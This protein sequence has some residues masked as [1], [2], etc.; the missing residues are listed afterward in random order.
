MVVFLIFISLDGWSQTNRESLQ[1]T[2]KQLEEEIKYTNQLLEQTQKSKKASLSKINLLQRQIEKREKL[3]KTINN[4]IAEIDGEIA[5]QIVEVNKKA[6][7]LRKMKDEYARLIYFIYKNQNIYNRIM[8]IFAADDFNQAYN[9]LKYYQQYTVYR[10]T[11][12]SLVRKAQ[13]D[14]NNQIKQLAETKD[15]KTSLA[16]KKAQEKNRLITEKADKDKT[17]QELTQKEKQLAAKLKEKQQASYKLQIEIE[18]L[19]AKEIKASNEKAKKAAKADTKTKTTTGVNDMVLTPVEKELST[20]FAANRGKLPWPSEKGVI[21]SSFGEHSHPVLKHVKVKNNGID[22]STEENAG[23]RTVFA[24][25][26]SRVMSFPNMNYVVIIRH[27][28][29]LT[30]YSN[31]DEVMVKDGQEVKTKQMIGRVH[32]NADEAK[33]EYHF[34]LWYGKTILNPQLW[35]AGAN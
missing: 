17:V 33:T 34:E 18:K 20:S 32:A 13:N 2:K 10:R 3:L 25:K 11:Q 7:E 1:R 29:Y 9:R 5:T 23:I 31:L 26:V 12:A 21:T 15:E 16:L 14:L 8:F 35:L 22:I 27:G 4:E 28:E 19:I 30:V 24:G 6:S